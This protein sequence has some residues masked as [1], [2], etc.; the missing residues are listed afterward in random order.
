MFYVL[1]MF[2]RPRRSLGTLGNRLGTRGSRTS[3]PFSPSLLLCDRRGTRRRSSSFFC[4][5]PCGPATRSSI[6]YRSCY[7]LLLLLCVAFFFSSSLSGSPHKLSVMLSVSLLSYS[8]MKKINTTH[9]TARRRSLSS[10]SSQTR[11]SGSPA[12]FCLPRHRQPFFSCWMLGAATC[13]GI[14]DGCCCQRPPHLLP[15][16]ILESSTSTK[17][18]TSKMRERFLFMNG[19]NQQCMRLPKP[20]C[21]RSPP[22]PRPPPAACPL[23]PPA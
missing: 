17:W 14:N 7:C 6:G 9:H 13:G 19:A 2:F 15:S 23:R 10:L 16:Q 3:A 18:E 5:L 22:W 20:P 21:P 1:N 11:H 8:Q 12:P 4:L